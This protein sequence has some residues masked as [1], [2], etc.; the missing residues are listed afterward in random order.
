MRSFRQNLSARQA[1]FWGGGRP[2]SQ[3]R[4]EDRSVT[5][6]EK[7]VPSLREGISPDSATTANGRNRRR[8]SHRGVMGTLPILPYCRRPDRVELP[9]QEPQITERF[10]CKSFNITFVKRCAIALSGWRLW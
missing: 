9:L 7:A 8:G 10:N 2:A 1:S 3:R 5:S 6:S 4:L